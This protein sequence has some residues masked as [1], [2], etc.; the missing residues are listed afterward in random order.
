MKKLLFAFL[1][2]LPFILISCSDDDDYTSDDLIGTWKLQTITAVEVKTSSLDV[3][4]FVEEEISLNN[5]YGNKDVYTFN[6]DGTFRYAE[7][8]TSATSISGSYTMNNAKLTT[9]SGSKSVKGDI[10]I[11][12]NNYMITIDETDFYQEAVNDNF[13]NEKVNKVLVKYTYKRIG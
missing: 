3:T 5:K 4:E 1:L 8:Q 11:T 10:S 7:S 13:D 9:T 2:L 6:S 12:Q